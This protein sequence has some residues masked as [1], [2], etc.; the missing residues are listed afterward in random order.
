LEPSLEALHITTVLICSAIYSYRKF[1]INTYKYLKQHRN[2][3]WNANMHH[4]TV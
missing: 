1:L 2:R 4:A 3:S